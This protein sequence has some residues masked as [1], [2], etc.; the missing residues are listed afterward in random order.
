MQ[1][2]GKGIYILAALSHFEW[3]PFSIAILVVHNFMSVWA[4]M[5]TLAFE[6]FDLDVTNNLL[7]Y[8][9]HQVGWCQFKWLSIIFMGWPS[10][11]KN[12]N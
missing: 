7:V 4:S 5:K 10:D 2:A 1:V 6:N 3:G 8:F 11:P 12:V 9:K